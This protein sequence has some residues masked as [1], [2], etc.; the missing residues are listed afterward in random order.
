MGQKLL[1]VECVK[2]NTPGR[3]DDADFLGIIQCHQFHVNE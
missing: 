1:G 2:N 3:K